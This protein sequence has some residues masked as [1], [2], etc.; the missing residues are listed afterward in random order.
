MKYDVFANI[1]AMYPTTPAKKI[2]EMFGVPIPEIHTVANGMGIYKNKRSKDS[3]KSKIVIFY[4][5][6]TGE[7]NYRNEKD[8]LILYSKKPV[9]LKV[10]WSEL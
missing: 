1:M 10:E 2:S 9:K 4:N 6:R 8:F 5:A 3:A 7:V